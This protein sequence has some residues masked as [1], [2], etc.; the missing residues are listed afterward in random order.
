MSTGIDDNVK[1]KKLTKAQRE[2]LQADQI[3][4]ARVQETLN[5][6]Y[7]GKWA[8]VVNYRPACSCGLPKSKWIA[9]GGGTPD[10]KCYRHPFVPA[11]DVEV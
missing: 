10:G 11:G 1:E 9:A 8:K 5:G 6:W 3:A 7:P 2:K 4:T